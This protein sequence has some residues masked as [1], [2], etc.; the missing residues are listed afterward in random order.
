MLWG[1]RTVREPLSIVS[2]SSENSAV[3]ET[4]NG[5]ENVSQAHHL[6]Q[7]FMLFQMICVSCEPAYV[8]GLFSIGEIPILIVRGSQLGR[9]APWGAPEMSESEELITLVL[10]V[11]NTQED[12]ENGILLVSSC[13]S[14]WW[15]F[16]G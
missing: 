1:P 2:L 9:F 11:G 15:G 7:F 8:L 6:A 5:H 10:G 3:K 14:F 13:S 12:E 16:G 4:E